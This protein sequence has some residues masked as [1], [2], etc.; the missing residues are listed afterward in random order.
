MTVSDKADIWAPPPWWKAEGD[1]VGLQGFGS[2]EG[3]Y[4][5]QSEEEALAWARSRLITPSTAGLTDDDVEAISA[6][7]D[8]GNYQRINW[9]FYRKRETQLNFRLRA[10]LSKCVIPDGVI[11]WRGG[12]FKLY[13]Y[14]EQGP[15]IFRGGPQKAIGRV[16]DHRPPVSTSVGNGPLTIGQRQ[17]VW[18]KLRIDPGVRGLFIPEIAVKGYQEQE[19]LLAPATRIRIDS[20]TLV[21]DR[22][23]VL[24]TA[25][26]PCS[27]TGA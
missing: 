16:F 4:L 18:Y 1:R 12:G 9:N 19:L 10:A 15:R 2:I 17:P 11:A 26:A 7:S 14:P 25:L 20:A 21:G 5:R 24:A 13:R 23:Y 3:G 27:P 6:Y 22:W 8:P